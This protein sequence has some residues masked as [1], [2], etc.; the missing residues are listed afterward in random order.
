M[1]GLLTCLQVNNSQAAHPETDRTID[2]ETIVVG[3]SMTNGVAHLAE[4]AAI[5]VHS[6]T[7]N[8]SYDSTHIEKRF[9]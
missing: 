6:I 1:N 9:K 3:S 7:A 2:V 8:Y 4:Q 5:D